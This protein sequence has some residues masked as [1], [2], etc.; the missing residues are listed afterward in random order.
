[1][2]KKQE[3]EIASEEFL[4]LFRLCLLLIL[5]SWSAAAWRLKLC[6]S[7][8]HA[9]YTR[10]YCSRGC[11]RH[12]RSIQSNIWWT[13]YYLINNIQ[14][15]SFHHSFLSL[16]ACSFIVWPTRTSLRLLRRFFFCL[17]LIWVSIQKGRSFLILILLLQ[18]LKQVLKVTY[19][20]E[21]VMV[22]LCKTCRANIHFQ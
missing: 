22:V 11:V 5:L 16:Q 6:L 12:S 15:Y 7:Q 4:Y 13:V 10:F 9:L 17:V 3:R 8:S 2:E 19:I 18:G 14:I 1:M 20:R 21:N